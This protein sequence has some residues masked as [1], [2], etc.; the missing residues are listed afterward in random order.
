MLT[1]CKAPEFRWFRGIA[2][3]AILLTTQACWDGSSAT[4]KS[5]DTDTTDG[6]GDAKT[7]L[8]G[9]TLEKAQEMLKL[10]TVPETGESGARPSLALVES[11]ELNRFLTNLQ[12]VVVSPVVEV[13]DPKANYHGTVIALP[14]S[15]SADVPGVTLS[16]FLSR[17]GKSSLIAAP[18]YSKLGRMGGVAFVKAHLLE[19][20]YSK[21]RKEKPL[22]VSVIAVQ[23]VNATGLA[24]TEVDGVIAN[25]SAETTTTGANEMQ[26]ASA[27]ENQTQNGNTSDSV[28]PPI[29]SMSGEGTNA[30]TAHSAQNIANTV[31]AGESSSIGNGA[32]SEIP[33][34]GEEIKNSINFRPI[35]GLSN[36]NPAPGADSPAGEPTRCG[37]PSSG[38]SQPPN[39]GAPNGTN[40][41]GEGGNAQDCLP[42]ARC[43][44]GSGGHSGGQANEDNQSSAGGGLQ[45]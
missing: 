14:V 20:D 18:E 43:F 9:I 29:G 13:T 7:T 23:K 40:L 38:S 28:L 21:G 10:I 24:L 1:E 34:S 27:G 8:K 12:A 19:R 22:V 4:T 41:D 36:S 17:D 3:L 44:Q 26:A 5:R 25:E 37:I 35:P 6:G 39:P 11:D 16:I 32:E 33:D 42:N 30:N 45:R 15:S 2:V 31:R